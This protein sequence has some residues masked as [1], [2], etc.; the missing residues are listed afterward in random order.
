MAI[1]YSNDLR[2]RVVSF[3]KNNKKSVK[4]TTIIFGVKKSA[5]YEWLKRYKETG[6]V[7]PFPPNSGRKPRLSYDDLA[8]IKAEIEKTPD[9][10]LQ[11]IKDSL[12]LN[13]SIC[14]LSLAIRNKLNFRYKK[15][16]KS[17]WSK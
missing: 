12:Q 9:K 16:S 17:R 8:L 15:N 3:I 6:S 10:T 7:K 5:I 2:E 11:E 14:A 1:S 4:E 13:I